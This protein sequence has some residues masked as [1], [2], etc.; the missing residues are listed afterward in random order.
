MNS[1]GYMIDDWSKVSRAPQANGSNGMLIR[2]YYT[3]YPST[4]WVCRVHVL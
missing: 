1:L 4:E 2:L 3:L